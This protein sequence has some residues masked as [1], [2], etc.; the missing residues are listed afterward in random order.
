[1]PMSTADFFR[2]RLDATINLRHPLA[3]LARMPWGRRDA[4]AGGCRDECGGPATVADSVCERW[5]QDEY[6]QF[7][8]RR[9]LR[10]LQNCPKSG[11]V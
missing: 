3:V 1:M 10:S 7:F 6:F 11:A 2:S 4:C 8:C 5:A 9:R